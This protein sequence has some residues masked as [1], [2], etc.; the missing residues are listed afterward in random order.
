MSVL[1]FSRLN[2]SFLYT[3]Y[4]TLLSKIYANCKLHISNPRV[5]LGIFCIMSD[6]DTF[7]QISTEP[8]A[9]M[10]SRVVSLSVCLSLYVSLFENSP[11]S[12]EIHSYSLLH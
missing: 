11:I 2:N 3:M 1:S 6:S 8:S 4:D 9:Y 7:M 12:F 10:Q 5:T